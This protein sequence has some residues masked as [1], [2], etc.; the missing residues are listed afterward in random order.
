MQKPVSRSK[1]PEDTLNPLSYRV[2]LILPVLYRRCAS[3]RLHDMAPWVHTWALPKMCA[4]V[5]TTSAEDGSWLTSLVLERATV[6]KKPFSGG[7]VDIMKCF[8]QL[9]RRLIYRLRKLVSHPKYC[10]PTNGFENHSTYATQC[11]EASENPSNDVQGYL[12]GVR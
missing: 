6:A 11:M 7:A 8:D 5:E 3:L 10:L 4:G 1:D 9:E 12:K 2:L